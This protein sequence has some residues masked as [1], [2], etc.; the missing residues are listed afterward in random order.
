MSA[1]RP[2]PRSFAACRDRLV[3]QGVDLD[4]YNTIETAADVVALREALGYGQW[5][6]WGFSYGGRVAQEVLRQ[7]PNG[8]VAL[9]LDSPLT[10]EAV[11]PAAR[12]ANDAAS[13]A[14]LSTRAPRSLR[15]P[16]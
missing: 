9:I 1:A 14:T 7:D 3:G 6:V 16:R 13:T 10:A 4:G 15:V 11:G 2:L 5:I 12:I 8:V